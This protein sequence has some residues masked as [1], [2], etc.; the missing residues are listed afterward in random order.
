M[1]IRTKLVFA[2]V[3]V[4]LGCML[5]LGAATYMEVSTLLRAR[6]LDQLAG[7]AEAKKDALEI[8]ASGWRERVATLSRQAALLEGLQD[9]ERRVRGA[10]ARLDHALGDAAAS[11][12]SLNLLALYDTTGSLVAR[13][14]GA[15]GGDGLAAP[16]R[17]SWTEE[18]V[19]YRG[20]DVSAGSEP[21]IA[22]SAPLQ[23]EGR[24]LGTLYVQLR[25]DAL[26]RLAGTYAGLGE[27]GETMVLAPLD[28]GR[29]QVLHPVRFPKEGAGTVVLNRGSVDPVFQALDGVEGAV[30]DGATDYR[31]SP[32]W[33]VTRYLPDLGWGLVVKVDD[34]EERRPIEDFRG[35][36]TR[37]GLSLSAF[38]ILLGTLLGLRLAKPIHDLAAVANQI[39]DGALSARAVVATEDEVGLLARTFNEMADELEHRMTALQEYRKFFDVSLDMLCIAGTDGYF[40]QTNPSFERIL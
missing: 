3:A 22:F 16:T 6:T 24:P 23:V 40:K 11:S 21:T 31:G 12:P 25:G 10:A 14:A 39:R 38:A 27:T 36:L 2:Y 5:A 32:V 19:T 33:A 18:G 29:A 20:V 4:A 1:D 30:R 8:I 15:P 26:V 9:R 7:L 17:V 13:S 28:D 34:R 35:H 37:L